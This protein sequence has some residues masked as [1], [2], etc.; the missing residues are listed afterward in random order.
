MLPWNTGAVVAI[1]PPV[2]CSTFP[3]QPKQFPPPPP[4]KKKKKKKK[5]KLTLKS[6]PRRYIIQPV[7]III[8]W[9][10]FHFIL[11]IGIYFL[12][13]LFIGISTLIFITKPV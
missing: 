13:L 2:R 10:L 4:K 8:F 6:N 1:A 5:S 11:S 12:I 3:F 9:T 7:I